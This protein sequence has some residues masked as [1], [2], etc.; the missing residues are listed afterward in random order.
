MDILN[1]VI[2]V[3]SAIIFRR[4]KRK[5]EIIQKLRNKIANLIFLMR[6]QS[7]EVREK[8]CEIDG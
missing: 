8:F 2:R 6:D 1:N 7:I 3:D 5:E 4:C